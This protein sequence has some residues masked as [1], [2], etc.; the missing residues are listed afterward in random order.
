MT[1]GIILCEKCKYSDRC[2]ELIPCKKYEPEQSSN[3]LMDVVQF[4]L[5]SEVEEFAY[6]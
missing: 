2:M 1:I 6:S 3:F 5:K 4:K